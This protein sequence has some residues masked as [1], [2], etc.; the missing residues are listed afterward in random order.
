MIHTCTTN[1]LQFVPKDVH[2]CCLVTKLLTEC[3]NISGLTRKWSL[4]TTVPVAYRKHQQGSSVRRINCQDLRSRTKRNVIFCPNIGC[5]SPFIGLGCGLKNI[6]GI[7]IFQCALAEGRYAGFQKL[8]RVHTAFFF[9]FF[10]FCRRYSNNSFTILLTQHMAS[11]CQQQ[12]SSKFKINM[13]MF[14]VKRESVLFS[15]V[16]S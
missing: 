10:P 15:R 1:I 11:M 13:K 8:L 6:W 12:L 3:K 5:S 9:F 14:L 16:F 7:P 2:A 4:F